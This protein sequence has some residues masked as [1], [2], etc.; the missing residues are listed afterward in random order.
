MVSG[1]FHVAFE[2]FPETKLLDTAND[3]KT[4][5][6]FSLVLDLESDSIVLIRNELFLGHLFRCIFILDLWLRWSIL[7][8]IISIFVIHLVLNHFKII[9]S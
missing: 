1:P 8:S 2:F 3:A 9:V 4:F 7:L 6:K 5:T